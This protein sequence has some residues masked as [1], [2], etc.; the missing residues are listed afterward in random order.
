MKRCFLIVLDG[1]GLGELPDADLYGD[2]GS[3]TLVHISEAVGGISLPNLEKLGLGNI[4]PIKGVSRVPE[5]AA[6]FGKLIEK[7][8]GKDSTTGHWELAGIITSE[9]FP[10]YPNGFPEN[11][12]RSI[13]DRTGCKDILG[14]IT[15]SGTEIISR[16]G[17]QHLETGFPIV[18]TSADPVF[19]IAAHEHI[20]PIERLYE[21]CRIARNEVMIKEHEVSR[22]IARPFVGKPGAFERTV[23]RKDFS[24]EPKRKT[25]LD[26][27]SDSGIRTM[28]IGKVD[29]LFAGRGVQDS[30]HTK[31]NTEGIRAI[32]NTL[33]SLDSGFVFV[34]LVDFD[35]EFGHRN[36]AAGFARALIEFDS[37]VP[38]IMDA[39]YENDLL[40]LT[41]DHGNDPTT[42]G[43]DHTR[44]YGLL[45]AFFGKNGQG[46]NAGTRE[47][48]ADVAQTCAQYFSLPADIRHEMNGTS[49][50]NIFQ[51][52][53]K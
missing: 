11:I 40:I 10:L 9:P 36:D 31:N 4:I 25:L 17:Q 5:P 44:E 21:W 46:V 33:N 6:V 43:T 45:L 26:H 15:A 1:V 38:E 29:N 34:N 42:P 49:I 50:Y 28:T 14:N 3:S 32:I 30:L 8:A 47:T 53:S 48:F 7:S 23:N 2:V 41:S 35:Q 13:I 39:M 22:V 24:V 37:A 12:I 27:L 16:L 20:I 19:Q 51:T 18:Y 52:Q